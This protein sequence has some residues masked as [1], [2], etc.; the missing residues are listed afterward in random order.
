MKKL[1]IILGLV[2]MTPMLA[3]ADQYDKTWVRQRHRYNDEIYFASHVAL[4]GTWTCASGSQACTEVAGGDAGTADT[5]LTIGDTIVMLSG[6]LWYSYEVDNVTIAATTFSR[7]KNVSN[8]TQDELRGVTAGTVYIVNTGV[9]TDGTTTQGRDGVG[10]ALPFWLGDDTLNE[11]TSDEFAAKVVF[12]VNKA[13]SGDAYGLYLKF[14]DTLSPDGLYPFAIGI[15]DVGALFKIS[16]NGSVFGRSFSNNQDDWSILQNIGLN[17]SSVSRIFV[18][19]TTLSAGTKVLDYGLYDDGADEYHCFGDG[20][21]DGSA[22]SCDGPLWAESLKTESG[23]LAAGGTVTESNDGQLQTFTWKGVVD[24]GDLSTAGLTVDLATVTLPAKAVLHNAYLV[25]NV[26]PVGVATFTMSL[27]SDGAG[28]QDVLITSADQVGGSINT[29]FGD[30]DG[31]IGTDL[32]SDTSDSNKLY[33]YTAV[34]ALTIRATSTVQNL[35]QLSAGQWT[36]ILMYSV[37]P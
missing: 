19:D 24:F 20:D 37:L 2:L 29:V 13:T 32:D 12:T 9:A 30:A 33:S 1:L 16:N 6:S 22:G 28:G 10:N 17:L 21:G 25:I 23:L 3:F 27:D 35:D 5:E 7:V 8:N 18:S 31:E 26:V 14:I 34:Q 4:T 11:A 36:V 15:G